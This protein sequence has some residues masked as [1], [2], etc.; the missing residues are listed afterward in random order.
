MH[1]FQQLVI[2]NTDHAS[3]VSA[4]ASSANTA[5]EDGALVM[6]DM[7]QNMQAIRD[8]S[9]QIAEITVLIDA[10]AFQTNILA[11]N[12]A[13]EAARAGEQGR[14]FAVVA[15]EVRSLAARAG[16]A[17]KQIRYLIEQSTHKVRQGV[18]LADKTTAAIVQ[19]K[20]SV[21]SVHQLTS[22]IYKA[23]IVQKDRV[24]SLKSTLQLIDAGTQ[25]NAALVEQVA[26]SAQGLSDQ[27]A[28]LETLV[29]TFKLNE[30]RLQ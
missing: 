24:E 25:Q 6:N 18:I 14:G 23:S 2:T 3:N 9:I 1:E 26:A 8:S 21:D 4:L 5:A 16:E 10:I 11:L 27:S 7:R 19:V 13:V 12:A 30:R 17:A 28:Q 20:S 15:N 29:A 22:A